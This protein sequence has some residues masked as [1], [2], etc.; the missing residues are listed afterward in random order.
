LDQLEEP[1]RGSGDVVEE[2]LAGALARASEAGQWGIVETLGRE[3]EARRVARASGKGTA[4]V[5]AL[6]TRRR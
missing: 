1:P 5:V 3:L 4:A 2:A 6:A